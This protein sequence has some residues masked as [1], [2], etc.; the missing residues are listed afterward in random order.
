MNDLNLDTENEIDQEKVEY[1]G[2]LWFK[3]RLYYPEEPIF[4][5]RR[6]Y[7]IIGE[8]YEKPNSSPMHSEMTTT[9]SSDSF[10]E[11]YNQL[12]E[13]LVGRMHINSEFDPVNPTTTEGKFQQAI[14]HL[15][16]R[17]DK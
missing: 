10:E 6:M 13:I 4:G 16:K 9:S 15:K 5:N 2:D 3:F 12:M 7:V 14:R 1:E 17:L 11:K 8:L